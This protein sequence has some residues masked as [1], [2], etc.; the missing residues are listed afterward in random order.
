M[1]A[2][3]IHMF[4]RCVFYVS[5]LLATHDH[6]GS[7]L[8]NVAECVRMWPRFNL[9]VA[10][11]PMYT[12]LFKYLRCRLSI[13]SVAIPPCVLTCFTSVLMP[14]YVNDPFPIAPPPMAHASGTR[15]PSCFCRIHVKSK[16]VLAPV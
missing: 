7:R 6:H 12:R 1:S 2:T 16:D 8:P 15:G 11:L 4:S 3:L 5:C 9:N 10:I 14:S 13:L